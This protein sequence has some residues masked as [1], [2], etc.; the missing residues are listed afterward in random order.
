MDNTGKILSKYYMNYILKED[1]K[2][3]KYREQIW[4]IWWVLLKNR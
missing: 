4:R 1:W 3:L 2:L